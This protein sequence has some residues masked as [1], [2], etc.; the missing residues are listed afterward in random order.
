MLSPPS[1]PLP[2]SP[3]AFFANT[4]PSLPRYLIP[5]DSYFIFIDIVEGDDII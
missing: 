3:L 5:L 1:L 2:L 4:L